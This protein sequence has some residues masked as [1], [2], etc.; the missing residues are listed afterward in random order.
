M[1]LRYEEYGALVTLVTGLCVIASYQM[2]WLAQRVGVP[3]MAVA[4]VSAVIGGAASTWIVSLLTKIKWIRKLIVGSTWVE[5]WWVLLT[6]PSDGSQEHKGLLEIKY[7]DGLKLEALAFYADDALDHLTAK[8]Y[9]LTIDDKSMRYINYARVIDAMPNFDIIAAGE[10][11]FDTGKS[12]PTLYK[13]ARVNLGNKVLHWQAMSKIDDS[14]IRQFQL[15]HGDIWKNKLFASDALS[16][17][18][19]RASRMR[20]NHFK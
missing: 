2:P 5:G 6:Y 18:I 9:Y 13:G 12:Y 17:Y 7:I 20:R 19:K 3:Q 4:L 14:V 16:P 8:S 1:P 15:Q 10:L 11:H